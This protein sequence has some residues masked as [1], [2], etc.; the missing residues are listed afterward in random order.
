MVFCG[1]GFLSDLAL[2]ILVFVLVC[3]CVLVGL[4]FC[5]LF[6]FGVVFVDLF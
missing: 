2:V 1:F 3:C 5:G 4:G 6:G